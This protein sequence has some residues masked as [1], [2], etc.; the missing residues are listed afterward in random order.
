MAKKLLDEEQG[1]VL[2][3]LA[4]SNKPSLKKVEKKSSGIKLIMLDPN[5]TPVDEQGNPMEDTT[6]RKSLLNVLNGGKGNSIQ[7]LAFETDPT[8]PS[9]AATGIYVRKL[10]LLPDD[11]LKRIA[12]QDNLVA[13]III[14]RAHHIASFGRK[15][16]DRFSTGFKIVPL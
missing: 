14:A 1:G 2:K 9:E 12:I 10:R 3:A 16:P 11:I 5:S 13:A 6:L 7:R 4:A 15:Q 8:E